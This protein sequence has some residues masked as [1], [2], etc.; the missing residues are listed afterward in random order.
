MRH[1]TYATND[2]SRTSSGGQP[3][4]ASQVSVDN[5]QNDRSTYTEISIFDIPLLH[6]NQVCAILSFTT[7]LQDSLA[8][9]QDTGSEPC[10]NCSCTTLALFMCS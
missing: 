4:S 5:M 8:Y 9:V 2:V 6:A 10:D 7:T 3:A 1:E